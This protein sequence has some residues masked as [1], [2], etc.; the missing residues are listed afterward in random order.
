MLFST[1][2]DTSLGGGLKRFGAIFYD[3]NLPVIKKGQPINIP[4]NTHPVLF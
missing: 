3:C 4:V 2:L 1:L